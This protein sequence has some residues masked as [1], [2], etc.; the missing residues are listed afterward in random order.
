MGRCGAGIGRL[1]PGRRWRRGAPSMLWEGVQGAKEERSRFGP[2]T[3]A[4]PSA[5][6][7]SC[8]SWCPRPGWFEVVGRPMA[9]GIALPGSGL[10]AEAALPSA[11]QTDSPASAPASKPSAS[12]PP[13]DSLTPGPGP[14]SATLIRQP[15]TKAP[16]SDP[17]S[18]CSGTAAAG[19]RDPCG[20]PRGAGDEGGAGAGAAVLCRVI[21]HGRYGQHVH[22]C[23][24]TMDPAPDA[25]LGGL[26]PPGG[27][28]S[29]CG[30]LLWAFGVVGRLFVWR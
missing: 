22:L 12:S 25:S 19:R 11:V 28:V 9:L 30:A 13:R 2:R 26:R 5:P 21:K 17:T 6:S 3:A 15:P 8:A 24:T 16:A 29:M 7:G 4:S 10:A 1:H 20:W 23:A 27:A 18:E 14:S